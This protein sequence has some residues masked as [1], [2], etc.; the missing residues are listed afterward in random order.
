MFEPQQD[1]PPQ[2]DVVSDLP[3]RLSNTEVRTGG[4]QPGQL[5]LELRCLRLQH[6]TSNQ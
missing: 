1:A 4:F 2:L 5:L 6:A 3:D